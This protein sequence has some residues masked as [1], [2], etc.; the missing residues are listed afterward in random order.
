MARLQIKR[1]VCHVPNLIHE[2]LVLYVSVVKVNCLDPVGPTLYSL[3]HKRRATFELISI[4][5]GIWQG[6]RLT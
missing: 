4:R 2:F 1:R 6:R 3:S 5:F